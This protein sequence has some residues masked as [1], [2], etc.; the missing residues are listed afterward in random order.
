MSLICVLT[1]SIGVYAQ[2]RSVGCHRSHNKVKPQKPSEVQLKNIQNTIARSDTFDILHY[3]ISIDV[4]DYSN[5]TIKASTAVAFIPKISTGNSITFD[6]FE[7][8]VDSVT[9]SSGP[10]SFSYDM[11]FLTIY[12]PSI[13]VGVNDTVVV[14]YQGDPHKDANW[15]GFIFAN[16]YIYCLLYTSPSPR[17]A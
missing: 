14:H 5:Q 13:Q 9:H 4:T 11:E 8:Q 15:G 16:N 2:P 3:D 7:L 12:L 1:L 6:L 17:D 10:L